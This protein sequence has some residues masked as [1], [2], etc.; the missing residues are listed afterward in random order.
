MSRRLIG[1][2]AVFAALALLAPAVVQAQGTTGTIRGKVTDST[3]GEPLAAVNVVVFETDGTATTMGAMT[4]AEGDYV[5]VN[6]QPGRYDLRASMMGYKQVLVEDFLVTVG[7]SAIRNFELEPT[8]LDVGETV[9]VTAERELIQRDVSGTQESYTIEEMERM[10]VSSTSDILALQTNTAT[11]QN[12]FVDDIEGY[13]DRGLEQVHM[14]GGRNAEVAFMIDG[15]QVTN[16]VFGGQAAQISPFSLSEMVVMAG[17]MSAE[18]GNAMS[19]VVNMVTREGGTSYDANMQILSS[20]FSGADQDAVMNNTSMDGYVG[21]PIPM[22]DRLT[23]FAS[24]SA[25]H[26][27]DYLVEKDD[28][29][30]D[31]KANPLDPEWTRDPGIEY[32]GLPDDLADFDPDEHNPYLQRGPDGRRILPGDHLE[33]FLGYGFDNRW[34]GMLNLT[35]KL[36]PSM[37]ITGSG[38][39][40]GRWG[41]PYTSSWRYAMF[42]GMPSDFEDWHV[43]GYPA[44]DTID[45]STGEIITDPAT[46]LPITD[47]KNSGSHVISGSGLTDMENEK[48]ILFHDNRRAAFVWT[49]QMSQ[50][51]FYSVRGSHYT[52][53]RTMRVKR[54][55]NEEGWAR[56]FEHVY[57]GRDPILDPDTNEVIGYEPRDPYWTP[58][59]PMHRVTLLPIPYS[60]DTYGERAHGY[61]PMGGA[62]AGNDASDR[63]YT[64]HIDVTRTL[65][66]DITS[67]VTSHHQVKTGLIYNYLTLDQ[68]DLQLLYL[69][70]PYEVDYR[71]SPWE[72]G[73]YL[74]DKIEYDFLILNVGARYDGA[75]AGEIS[76]WT[77][78]RDVTDPETGLP[79]IDP[80]DPEQAPVTS[81]ELRSQISP[82]L[83]VS[84]PVTDASVIYF[85]YGHFFQ[86]PVYRN[87]YLEG[88]LHDSSPLI[89]NPNMENEKTVSYEFGYKQQFGE[90]IALDVSMWAKDTSNMVGSE[91][92]PAWFQGQTNPYGYTTFVNYD[93]ASSKG[94][95]VSLRKRYSDLWAGTMNYSFMTTQS[96]RD[97]P[98]SGYREGDDLETTPKRPRVLGWDRPHSFSA[99][100]SINVPEGVGPETFGVRPFE[101]V[102]ASLIYR[103]SA[104]RP[105]TPT[106]FDRRLDPNSGRRPW[107]FQWDARVYRDFDTFGMRF[108]VFA[109][110]RNLFDRKNIVN[111]YSRTGK[112]DDPG[113]DATGYSDSYDRSHYYGTPRRINLGLRIYF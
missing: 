74:Q 83:G 6:V 30:F 106:T 63:Y 87:L 72:V 37:K 70:P 41:T 65:K 67:Q 44:Y 86:N 91:R 32:Y 34:S 4:N 51:T 15:M 1:A 46:G 73:I 3:T 9:T 78:P 18:F 13:Y 104:G 55:V 61:F 27:R 39:V 84:H 93:Y 19:G 89:G 5:I 16:L 110:V 82:R 100:V 28:I 26:G 75:N 33:G 54:F 43:L 14:R 97:D 17:G 96:N 12:N 42:W 11:L 107:T 69:D 77:G 98:W 45:P 57:R 10:A 105:Y 60:A 85:N 58:E 80:G 22:V 53:D 111:V 48:N 94:V 24:G 23:F 112:A 64:N 90:L 113:P 79:V 59:D 108:S 76:Y 81:G 29:L 92:V 47:P 38:N 21:G 31:Y 8:V 49:H 20:E 103:A 101:K 62:A 50:A 25:S 66:A 102:N 88:T 71:H 52:Y 68:Y 109:D 7:V 56:R 35:Y 36:S 2:L 99:N 40:N 95:D